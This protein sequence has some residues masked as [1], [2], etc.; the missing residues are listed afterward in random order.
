MIRSEDLGELSLPELLDLV[1]LIVDEIQLRMMQ[2]AGNDS[3][4]L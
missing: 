1:R 3:D 4:L 2:Q